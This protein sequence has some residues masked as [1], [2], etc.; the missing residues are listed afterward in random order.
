MKIYFTIILTF[1][2]CFIHAEQI[3]VTIQAGTKGDKSWEEQTISINV[4]SI[5]T[6]KGTIKAPGQWKDDF[7]KHS[8]WPNWNKGHKAVGLLPDTRS[9]DGTLMLGLMYKTIIPESV[10]ITNAEG[11]ALKNGTDFKV[12]ALWGQVLGLT[13]KIGIEGKSKLKVSF[14]YRM[15]RIDIVQ[16]N[17][18]S[19]LSVQSG[20]EAILCPLPPD[21]HAG[22]INIA[23]IYVHPFFP[24]TGKSYTIG[25]EHVFFINPPKEKPV[26]NKNAIEKSLALLKEGKAIKIALLGDSVTLGAEAGSWWEDRS[27]TWTGRTIAGLKQRFPKAQITEIP[28]YKGGITT[29]QGTNF[30]NKNVAPAKPDLLFIALG[31]NDASGPAWRD[32]KVPAPEFKIAVQKMVKAAK[33]S[34]TEVILVTPFRG[35]PFNATGKRMPKHRDALIELANEEQVACADVFTA[36]EQLAQHGIAPYSQVHNWINHP[37]EFGHNVYAECVLGL[38]E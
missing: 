13:E 16:I 2:L 9:V 35:N 28:A 20:E 31:L 11:E 30:F 14:Q 22:A 27:K 5:Q 1:F 8:R 24:E 10:N 19:K 23:G 29:T 3:Q 7:A 33:E 6:Y 34:G 37:G 25:K 12:N 32:G 26:L 18:D 15:Q 21:V 38:F 36:W 17:A 4:P